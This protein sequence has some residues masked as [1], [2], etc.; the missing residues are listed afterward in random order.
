[1]RAPGHLSR[2]D[3]GEVRHPGRQ[4]ALGRDRR[5][6]ATRTR[7]CRSS[8]H[9][10]SRRRSWCSRNVPRIRDTETQVAAARAARRQGRVGQRSRDPAA[11]RRDRRH[12]G[13]RGR[14]GADPRLVPARRPAAGALRRRPDAAAR[15]RH[16]RP[17]PAR[18]AP[19]RL[20]RPRRQGQ[21]R[22]LDRDHGPVRGA[23][24]VPRSSW[25]SPR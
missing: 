24:A 17:P 20:P 6:R 10:C 8:P 25:T 4:P 3:H 18:S 16:D 21:R 19:R 1:M 23:E 12:R 2:A 7:P 9:A 11:G 5:R 14:R 15:R 22:A 13:R